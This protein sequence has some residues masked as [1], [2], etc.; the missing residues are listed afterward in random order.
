MRIWIGLLGSLACALIHSHSSSMSVA[1][2]RM[3]KYNSS[4]VVHSNSTGQC[5]NL[6]SINNGNKTT[7]VE[8]VVR[9]EFDWSESVQV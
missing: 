5:V 4:N 7:T 2:V 3:A 9:G 1:I 6:D 8:P